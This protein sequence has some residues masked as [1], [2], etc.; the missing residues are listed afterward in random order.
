[1]SEI[2]HFEKTLRKEFTV[3]VI[4]GLSFHN[5]KLSTACATVG[6][7]L[8]K[9]FGA[10]RVLSYIHE[11]EQTCQKEFN[12]QIRIC[13]YMFTQKRELSFQKTAG[14]FRMVFR[15]FSSG[16][17]SVHIINIKA[18]IKSKKE[19]AKNW[20]LKTGQNSEYCF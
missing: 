7:G 9:N 10:A 4:N 11:Q 2:N 6:P 16:F 12:I 3:K 13:T 15:T 5:Y 19:G 1:M 18:G 8:I 17:I 20:V 14:I